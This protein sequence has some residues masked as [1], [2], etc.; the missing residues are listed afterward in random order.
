MHDETV[1]RVLL[2]AGAVDFV[3]KGATAEDL[4]AAIRAA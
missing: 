1:G 4:F 3:S 2:E